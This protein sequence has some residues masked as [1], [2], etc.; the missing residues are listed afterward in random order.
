MIKI[1]P[2]ETFLIQ[3][4][5]FLLLWLWDD[6][7]ATILSFSFIGIFFSIWILSWIVEWIEPSKVP[8]KYFSYVLACALAPTVVTAVFF[9][10]Y[11]LPDWVFS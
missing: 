10:I 7:V 5:I 4:V 3:V 1:S 11:G 6:Y 8:K 2:F 9:G